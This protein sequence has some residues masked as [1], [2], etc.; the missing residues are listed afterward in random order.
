[1]NF[2]PILLGMIDKDEKILWAGKP[3]FKCF[4]LEAIFNPLLP[5]AVVW[6]LFDGFFISSVLKG[7]A[8]ET[9]FMPLFFIGF[10][11]LHLMP[12]W[13]YLG[14]VLFSVLKYKHTDF[15][16]T[17]K[18]V[19]ASGG[20]FAQ[21]FD[22]KKFSDIHHIQIHRG[23]FDQWIGVGDVIFSESGNVLPFPIKTKHNPFHGIIVCDIA[24]YQ[25]VYELAKEN[26]KI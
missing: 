9:P 4:V 19:Y 20:M 10:F 18:G 25:H 26:T 22:H 7:P 6:G 3:N 21:T 11:M 24:D 17:D 2:N 5:F 1:M 15:I 8:K 14:G 23:L 16:L 13:I 12:V